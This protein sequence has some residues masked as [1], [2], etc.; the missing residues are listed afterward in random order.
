MKSCSD[1]RLG[2]KRS[3]REHEIRIALGTYLLM[4]LKL[5]HI[6]SERRK[7]NT[8]TGLSVHCADV[9]CGVANFHG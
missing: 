8:P 1:W 5:C 6:Y 4:T 7:Q 3:K 2:S 9:I